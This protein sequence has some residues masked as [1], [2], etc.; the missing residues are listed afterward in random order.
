MAL[1]ELEVTRRLNLPILVFLM[2]DGCLSLI[3]EKQRRRGFPNVGMDFGPVDW[4]HIAEGFG[5]RAVRV[6]TPEQLEAVLSEGWP[7]GPWLVD[8]RLDWS[9]YGPIL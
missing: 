2:D 7:D 9:C 4:P 8:V 5:L 3:K 1:H 6:E